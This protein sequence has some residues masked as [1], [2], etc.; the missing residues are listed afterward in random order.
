M[1]GGSPSILR[2]RLIISYSMLSVEPSVKTLIFQA[3]LADVI[4]GLLAL[5]ADI[6][7]EG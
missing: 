7:I 3:D 1:G 2:G 4:E 5:I 6:P